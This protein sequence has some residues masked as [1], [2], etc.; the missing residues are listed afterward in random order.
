MTKDSKITALSMARNEGPFL[1]EW[2]CWYRM[3]GFDITVM[4]NDCTDR[5]PALLDALQSHGWLRHIRHQPEPGQPPKQSGYRV[6]QNDAEFL[7]SDWALVCDID[8]F[9]VP[10]EAD[11]IQELLSEFP[12][13]TAGIAFPWRVFGNGGWEKYHYGQVHQQFRRAAPP[14]HPSARWFK[15]MIRNPRRYARMDDH[16]PAEPFT[17]WGASDLVWRDAAGDRLPEFNMPENHPIRLTEDVCKAPLARLHHYMIRSLETFDYRRGTPCASAGNDRY[18]EDYLTRFNLNGQRC[19][20]AYRFEDRFKPILH[21]AKALPDVLRL[22]HLCCA[23]YTAELVRH[24]GNDPE[25]DSRYQHHMRKATEAANAARTK[26]AGPQ[27]TALPQA[28]GPE[29]NGSPLPDH[30]RVVFSVCGFAPNE[31][32]TSSAQ[33][34]LYQRL[35]EQAGKYRKIRLVY[36]VNELDA[37]DPPQEEWPSNIELLTPVSITRRTRLLATLRYPLLPS[38]VS[39]RRHALRPIIEAQLADPEITDFHAECAQGAA[40]IPPRRFGLFT[41]WQPDIV[42]RLYKRCA[43][44]GRGLKRLAYRIE[45]WRARRWEKRAWPHMAEIITLSPEDAEEIR[46]IAPPASVRAEPV[47]GTVA[48]RPELRGPDTIIPG[49]IGFW[50]NMARHENVDA[51]AHMARNLLPEI[52]KQHPEAHFWII[53]AH[54]TD[55]VRALASDHVHVTGFVEDP[56]PIFATLNLAAAPLRLG[57]GVKIKV[58][59][60]LDAGIPTVVSPVGGEGIGAH[61]LLTH[62]GSDPEMIGAIT[63]ML[64]SGSNSGSVAE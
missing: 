25:Q 44:Q 4:T 27:E 6:L 62:A 54:P 51:V 32:A 14:H 28:A 60:T 23:D 19:L 24:A 35:V 61:P 52:R 17:G 56:A 11:T 16:A 5:S 55:E 1:L 34:L 9:L 22:H 18:T 39:A 7:S 2:V 58:F 38:F 29:K 63:Q 12:E 10:N 3:L 36:F 33:K 41:V 31:N 46:A 42:S 43:D 13:Q 57:S 37:L 53:G 40:A 59:E 15:S 64:Q 50:G 45:A 48:A 20:T 26:T 30:E 21:A 49:R 8:E 47:R